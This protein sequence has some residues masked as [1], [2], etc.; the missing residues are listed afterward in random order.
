MWSACAG[1]V[2]GI[3]S[4][5]GTWCH[6]IALSATQ[7]RS[8]IGDV[9]YVSLFF[10]ES[11]LQ[12]CS[13]MFGFSRR[14]FTNWLFTELRFRKA[15]WFIKLWHDHH[16]AE[17]CSQTSS[18]ATCSRYCPS[19]TRSSIKSCLNSHTSSVY[20]TFFHGGDR[21]KIDQTPLWRHVVLRVID[22]MMTR[23]NVLSKLPNFQETSALVRRWNGTLCAALSLV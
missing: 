10:S 4:R 15:T 12:R 17:R 19:R 1:K 13:K 5:I 14:F 2:V 3:S 7:T 23:R 20:S 21:S 18:T 11:K 9:T 8:R 22:E 6:Q 16:T